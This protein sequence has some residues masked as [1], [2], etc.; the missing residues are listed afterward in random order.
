[1][2]WLVFALLATV[3]YGFY[4]F[5]TKLSADKLSPAIA[6]MFVGIASFLVGLASIGFSKI[7]GHPILFSRNALLFPLLAGLFAGV[8]EI[9]YLT[10]FSK[11]APLS[12]GNPLVVGGTVIISAV[13]GLLFL[14][15][16]LN[17]IKI[18]GIALTL[19]GLIILARG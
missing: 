13:L 9:F 10:M 8:A 12:I 16:P 19:I 6:L 14:K 11:G 4:N 3:T 1:M 5:F 15:E 2:N 7:L 17:A 18:G